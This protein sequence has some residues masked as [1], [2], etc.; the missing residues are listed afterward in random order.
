MPS[1]FENIALKLLL[2]SKFGCIAIQYF[3][4]FQPHKLSILKKIF[5]CVQLLLSA[6]YGLFLSI[7]G[8]PLI[9]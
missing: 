4:N 7:T 2:R 1:C 8:D 9:H 3:T 6:F 5:F